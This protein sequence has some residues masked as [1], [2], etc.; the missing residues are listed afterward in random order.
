MNAAAIPEPVRRQ[1]ED[2]S[3]VVPNPPVELGIRRIVTP[4]YCLFATPMPSLTFVDALRLTEDE[5]DETIDEVRRTLREMGRSQALWSVGTSARPDGLAGLLADRGMTP[6]DDPPLEPSGNCMAIVEPPRLGDLPD[7]EIQLAD[8]IERLREAEE[9]ESKAFGIADEDRRGLQSIIEARLRLQQEERTVLRQWVAYLDAG[10]VGTGRGMFLA[11]GINL[12]GAAV[13][14][15]ARGH[16]IYRALIAH[17]WRDA[18]ERST[19][20]LTVQAGAMSTPILE[21]LGFVTVARTVH[22]RDRF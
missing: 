20:A 22:L 5:L 19:P 1:A 12:S 9:V 16:G 8:T 11:H 18:V 15:S 17:R 14:P 10:P 2:L 13:L 3:S 4:R 7:V 21:Q 6:Y